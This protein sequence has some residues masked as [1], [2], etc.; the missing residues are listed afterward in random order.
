MKLSEALHGLGRPVAY[1]PSLARW[2]GSV[3]TA[4]FLCQLLYWWP[5]R[6]DHSYIYKQSAQ[7]EEETGL[8]YKAQKTARARL[9]TM[10]ILKDKNA[11]LQHEV[12]FWID[13]A[14]LD[15]AWQA[16]RQ[17]EGASSQEG[18]WAPSQKDVGQSTARELGNS[19]D[20]RSAKAYRAV[21]SH[22]IPQRTPPES[23]PDPPSAVPPQ[24][25]P[26]LASADAEDCH[27]SR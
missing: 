2:L 27:V 23:T 13:E 26:V 9:K 20:G 25:G 12:H 21:R 3:S 8:S 15:R 11:R 17:D 10:G 1:Y 18:K 5:R 6:G 14:V 22:R 19:P 4:V 24:G 7:L 16:Y